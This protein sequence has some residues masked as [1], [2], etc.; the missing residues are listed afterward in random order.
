MSV[1]PSV[2]AEPVVTAS[3]LVYEQ[4]QAGSGASPGPRDRVRVHYR[5][6]FTDGREFDSSY[7]RGQPIDFGLSQ[8]IAC[9]TEGLQRMQVGGKAR[10]IC[11]PSIAYGSRGAGRVIP[12]NATLMFEVELIDVLR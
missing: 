10:L 12:P 9:W 4:L 6:T 1:A 2:L 5:G 7:G 3:G 11:P 8:V